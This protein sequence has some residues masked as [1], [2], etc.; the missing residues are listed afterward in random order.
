MLLFSPPGCGQTLLTLA[1]AVECGSPFLNL[2]MEDLLHPMYA[3]S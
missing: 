2:H 1:T 3:V